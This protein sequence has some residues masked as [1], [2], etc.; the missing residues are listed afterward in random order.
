MPSYCPTHGEIPE[1]DQLNSAG[2]K[3][4]P[5][6]INDTDEVCMQPL[7]TTQNANISQ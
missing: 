4:C 3:F 6:L 7:E 5:V 1:E 2:G